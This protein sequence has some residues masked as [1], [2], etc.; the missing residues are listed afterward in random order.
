MTDHRIKESWHNLPA[1]MAGGIEDV[2]EV[3]QNAQAGMEE[4]G[5]GEE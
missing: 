4:P 2:I 5:S 3:L 1:I